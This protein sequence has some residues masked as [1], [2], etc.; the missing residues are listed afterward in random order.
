MH[1][2]FSMPIKTLLSLH[3]AHCHPTNKFFSQLS[4]SFTHTHTRWILGNGYLILI[5]WFGEK[6]WHNVKKNGFNCIIY[7]GSHSK[8]GARSLCKIYLRKWAIHAY[9][10]CSHHST[11][12]LSSRKFYH[13]FPK[14][15][16][17][18]LS[19]LTQWT[20]LFLFWLNQLGTFFSLLS[21]NSFSLPFPTILLRLSFS[22]SFSFFSFFLLRKGLKWH[23]LELSFF[24]LVPRFFLLHSLVHL[25]QL[26]HI[27]NPRH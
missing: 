19:Y 23:N 22:F 5:I 9:N 13:S 7:S 1:S 11:P 3:K 6:K 15:K 17:L 2:S 21:S 24:L 25:S 14:P 27:P 4:H 20:T 8:L 10:A 12:F 16:I 18:P 26:S